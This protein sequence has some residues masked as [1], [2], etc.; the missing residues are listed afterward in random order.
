MSNKILIVGGVAGGASAAARL[1]RN[2][3]FA[4]IIMFERG[5]YISFAN[6]G[7]PYYIGGTITDREELLLQTPES[8][9][10]RFNVDVR[11]L[12]EVISIDR[13]NQVVEV[14]NLK[15]GS[16]YKESYDKLILSPGSTPLK[17]P[18]PGINSPNI[19]TLWN[20]P[21]VD[22]LK[23]FVTENELRSA[24]VIGGGFIGLEMAE[25]LH[26]LGLTVSIAEMAPQVMTPIDY[27]MVQILHRHL[28]KKGVK[29]YLNN[30]VKEFR[31]RGVVTEVLL[32]NGQVIES[33]L[34]MLAIG[35]RPNNELAQ[36]AGLELNQRGGIVVDRHML[37]SDPNIYAV[38]DVVEV[39]DFVNGEKTMIPL[40]GPANKQGR[41]VA[42]HIA[43]IEDDYK[44]TQGTSV[45]KVFDLTVASTGNNEKMLQRS[46]QVYGKDYHIS[47]ISPGSHAGYYPG[48]TT[49]VLKLIFDNR[50]KILGAQAI[51]E[52]GVDKR[53]DVL[54]TVIRFGGHVDDLTDLELA[55]APPYS[56]AKD[57]VNMVGF[58]AQNQLSGIMGVI[59]PEEIADLN[60][61]EVV[62][63][64][65]RTPGEV[66]YGSIEGMINIPVDELRERLNELPKDKD[67]VIYCAVGIRG[68]ITSS[69][70]NAH[71]YKT[72]NLMGG[73][74]FY[75]YVVKAYGII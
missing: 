32:S 34:V 50:G 52:D 49:M 39:I 64:D 28:E 53:I 35:I 48:A 27:D 71:G 60:L 67:I 13:D 31:N 72:R 45:A 24:T 23:H 37:T 21:D 25:N 46:G 55:Y 33:D 29:L 4:E 15:D 42:N 9:N 59:R 16:S 8:F 20:I 70:L 7:L 2:D 62:L 57:P 18:I 74:N 47:I 36:E 65:V 5:E 22:N 56:S 75:K 17:P 19:F 58:V 61:D 11:V 66:K 30:G 6:C 10:E 43:G 54:A 69:I 51:G 38:G 73:Y 26:D 44:G 3:E 14:K 41:I 68:Y 40:A 63:L 1:R 12:N